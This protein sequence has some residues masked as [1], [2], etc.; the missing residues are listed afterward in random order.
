MDNYSIL[1]SNNNELNKFFES[2]EFCLDDVITTEK[3]SNIEL[4]KKLALY[5][6]T[7]CLEIK[8]PSPTEKEM[9]EYSLCNNKVNTMSSGEIEKEVEKYNT[10]ELAIQQKA[11][12]EILL[13]MIKDR[14]K[15]E[16]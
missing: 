3:L 9:F 2:R 7:Q 5:S 14:L 12:N 11:E 8:K 6:D 15:P 10:D 13:K 1:N 16:K 4:N